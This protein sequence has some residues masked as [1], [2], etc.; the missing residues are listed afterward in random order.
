MKEIEVTA[1]NRER[2]IKQTEVI[3]VIMM[4]EAGLVISI[5]LSTDLI[6]IG[7]AITVASLA[8][9]IVHAVILV[10]VQELDIKVAE[11]KVALSLKVLKETI[12]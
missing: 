2:S 10:K 9:A 3:A 6:I 12:Y 1:N 5:H 7:T 11:E 8:M 4:A